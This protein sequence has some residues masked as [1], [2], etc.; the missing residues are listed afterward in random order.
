[1]NTANPAIVIQAGPEYWENLP[2]LYGFSLLFAA[3]VGCLG[4]TF[5]LLPTFAS[6]QA[7]GVR[8]VMKDFGQPDGCTPPVRTIL[9]TRQA[10]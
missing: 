2:E 6:I 10:T 3:V 9:M 4:F 1:L 7:S 8:Q 5:I